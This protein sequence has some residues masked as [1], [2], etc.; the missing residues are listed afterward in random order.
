VASLR[1]TRMGSFTVCFRFE[2]RQFQ[3]ALKTKNKEDADA[4][5]KKVE[6]TLYEIARG[7][8]SIPDGVDPGDFIVNGRTEPQ[9][10]QPS[11]LP[12]S[13]AN[14]IESYLRDH[15][16]HKAPSS[17]GTERTHLHNLQRCLGKK[18]DIAINRITKDDL[19]TALRKRN[20]EVAATTVMKERQTLMSYFKWAKGKEDAQIRSSPAEDLCVFQEDREAERFR[21]L[22][23]IEQV[24]ARG[25]LSDLEVEKH[26][27]CLYLDQFQVGEVLALV[28]KRARHDFIFPMFALVAYTGMRRGEMLRLRWSDVNFDAR[29]IT[30]RSRKQ[31]RQT[32]QTSRDIPMHSR[33]REIL[34]DYLQRRPKGQHVICKVD[35]SK[36][37][38]ASMA[39]DH[40]QRTLRDSPWEQTMPSGTKKVVIGFHTFRH[41]IASNLAV[42]GVDQRLIDALMGHQTPQMTKRYQHLFPESRRAAVDVLSFDA[43]VSQHMANPRNSGQKPA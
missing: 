15:Q 5:Q 7:I 11:S 34:A 2:G 9:P 3:R 29:L 6:Y 1:K 39:H 31:S 18:S 30:A 32:E 28:E 23:E 20:D 25:G 27:E 37:L 8:Q 10:R 43:Q 24:L 13:Y 17:L 26:W 40:L 16:G 41:S 4:A 22:G 21:T 12:P 35:S 36:P 14:L 38:T 33:L 42:Q 19:E